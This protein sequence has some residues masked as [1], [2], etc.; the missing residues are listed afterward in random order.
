MTSPERAPHATASAVV[1]ART[2]TPLLLC[3]TS[4]SLASPRAQGCYWPRGV[5]W[6]SF[7]R[8]PSIYLISS[9]YLR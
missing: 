3:Q 4:W 5:V 7:R 8:A 9:W 6:G 1:H 2:R